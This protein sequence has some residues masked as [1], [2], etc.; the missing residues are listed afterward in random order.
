M[1][2][3]KSLVNERG[4]IKAKL[5]IFRKFVE[6]ADVSADVVAFE[7]RVRAN[8][9]IYEKF[10]AVQSRIEAAVVT[11][12]DQ[13]PQLAEREKFEDAYFR[14]ISKAENR[15]IQARG[16]AG[17]SSSIRNSDT[18]TPSV[19]H[20][21]S[22]LP[23]LKLTTFDGD[24][25]QWIRFRDTFCSLVH[26]AE[27]LNDIDRFNYLV[28]ALSGSAARTIESFSISSANYKLAW[29]RLRERYDDPKGLIAHHINSLLDIEPIRKPS[30]KALGQLVDTAVNNLSALNKLLK[31]EKVLEAFVSA[32]VTR[33]LDN[34]SCDEWE[35]RA[36][37]S[38][39]IPPFKELSR[40]LEQRSQHLARKETTRSVGNNVLVE[41]NIISKPRENRQKSYVAASHVASRPKQCLLCDTEHTLQNCPKFLAMSFPERHAAVKRS[42]ACFNCLGLGHGVGSCTRGNCRK[43]GT[44]HH[45]LLHREH[46]ST[47]EPNLVSD[48]AVSSTS[49]VTQ[50]FVAKSASAPSD[51]TV[52]S[53]AVV[54]VLDKQGQRH[55]CR[56]LLDVGSQANFIS[57]AFCERIALP[58]RSVE[59]MVGGLGRAQNPIKSRTSFEI[60]SSSGNFHANLSCLVIDSI[61][62]EMPNI[63]LSR[64]K[65][66]IPSGIFP[67][68]PEFS[69]SGRVDLLIGAG[70]FWDLLCVGQVKTG[71]GNLVWQKTR[72]GWV[73]GGSLQWP[74]S[75]PQ[76]SRVRAYH[77]VTN[78]Q[79]EKSIARFWEVEEIGNPGPIKNSDPCEDHFQ[80][81]TTRDEQGRFVV[82]L[83]F[84]DRI[85][86]LGESWSQAEKRLLNIERK[87]RRN[88]D[89]GNQYREFLREYIELGHMSR[90]D[91]ENVSGVG[92]SYYL[93]HHA[94]MKESSTTTKLRVV[95][96]GSA[97]TSTGISLNDAQ[98]IGRPVQDEL[99]SI[100]IRFR[101]HRIV[102]SADIAKMYRQVLVRPEDRK[103]QQILWRFSEDESIRAYSLNT[104]TYGT[105]S[106][107]Y[108]ATRALQQVGKDC[109][110][111]HPS[112][113]EKILK[114]F[115]VDDLLTGCETVKEAA[116]LRDSL[117]RVLAQAG[118]PLRKW[119]SNDPKVISH[120]SGDTQRLEFK[121]LDRETKT[122]GLLWYAS[123]DELGYTGSNTHTLRVT[124]RQVL[125]E[126]AQIFDPLGLIGPITVKA[127]LFMQELSWL[128][129]PPYASLGECYH[130]N[131]T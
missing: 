54:F 91:V 83:P 41:R 64:V 17:P 115:Y 9:N 34:V 57:R 87:F 72:L 62:E 110:Q 40:F 111:S 24:F 77:A 48:N 71:L 88:P 95:F 25:S 119:A 42:R 65:V 44:K 127:K 66:P 50:S 59:T 98:L 82:A 100:L 113:S 61:T 86:E 120:D 104:V 16:E 60:A 101:E 27:G 67:A 4:A 14:A 129:Y 108:L 130:L 103:Y 105:A 96:D 122:L 73:L 19:A 128:S 107:S 5:T 68:D 116:E 33:K 92:N 52:L 94:V 114:D 89:F 37:E 106:A 99:F 28:S 2:S 51:Y 55:K 15:L 93:P 69:Q 56:A 43:C 39:D 125:S 20:P 38:R 29:F 78:D 131:E 7:K 45:T 11:T 1:D 109:S 70:L 84:N 26:D 112:A 53:T 31:P 90:S 124:K 6:S 12:P 22:R 8:E 117:T 47:E 32:C 85:V 3:L 80:R 18:P 49:H 13:E 81:N 36:M 123:N 10:D 30:G 35:K 74:R 126:V 23:V 75:T 97:K 79:L 121:A 63:P 102:L 21:T 58:R 46:V 76:N 118:F